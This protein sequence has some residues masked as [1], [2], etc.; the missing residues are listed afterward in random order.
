MEYDLHFSTE[1]TTVAIMLFAVGD[2]T[3]KVFQSIFC[4]HLPCLKLSVIGLTC[5]LA[6]V[7]SG[8]MTVLRTMPLV[9]T[10]SFGEYGTDR[11][12]HCGNESQIQKQ[13]D[14]R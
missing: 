9:C 4:D 5:I 11:F 13:V 10:V 3:G 12:E 6:A 1:R 7:G 8:L 14:C 2:L